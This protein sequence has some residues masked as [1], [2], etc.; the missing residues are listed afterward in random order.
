MADKQQV[1]S[2]MNG[3]DFTKDVT[4]D[5]PG[6]E[7]GDGA[8]AGSTNGSSDNQSGASGQRDDDRYVDYPADISS[9]LFVLL[10]W[11]S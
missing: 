11:G 10:Q 1:D 5:G 9:F 8:A 7:N 4:A 3:E 2:E 6:S